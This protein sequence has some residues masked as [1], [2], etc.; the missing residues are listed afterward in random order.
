MCAR[1][2]IIHKSK[3]WEF[4]DYIQKVYLN[5]KL[6]ATCLIV[7]NRAINYAKRCSRY[8]TD[9]A[10]IYTIHTSFLHLSRQLVV[11]LCIYIS[12]KSRELY[13]LTR[14][15]LL[16]AFAIIKIINCSHIHRHTHSGV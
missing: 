5:E 10:K 9:E 1:D 3:V 12:D 8:K 15:G 4:L 13:R 16:V 2:Y 11:L 7:Q 6:N 14:S